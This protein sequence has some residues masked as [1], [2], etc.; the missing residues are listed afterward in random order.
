MKWP[1]GQHNSLPSRAVDVMPYPIDWADIPRME[2]F[3]V[4]VKDTARELGLK[5]E[6]GGDWK[7]GFID[8][9]HW[10]LPR[11]KTESA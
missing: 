5:V 4:V 3:A 2:A 6:W 11:A 1:N 10:E 8:R 9:P 7:G